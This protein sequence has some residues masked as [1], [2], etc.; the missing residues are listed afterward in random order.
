MS[1]APTLTKEEYE[2]RKQVL[3]DFKTLDKEEY[4]EVFRIIKRNG[5]AFTENSNG[6][7]FDLCHVNQDTIQQLMKFLE[8][9]KTQ[10]DNEEARSK[11]MDTLRSMGNIDA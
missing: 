10:R 5:V 8:L 9:S 11:E 7:H 3:E 1:G 2:Q 4:E 6:V